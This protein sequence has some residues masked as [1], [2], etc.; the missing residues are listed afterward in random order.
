[1]P[2]KLRL[3]SAGGIYHVINR[4]NYRADL[5]RSEKTKAAFLNCLDEACAKTGWRVHAWCLMSNHDHLA[6]ETPRANLVE[7][8]RWLQGTFAT[9]F[10]RAAAGT[11]TSVPRA[12]QE[13]GCRPGGRAG[14]VV[15]LHPSQSGAGAGAAGR[16][17]AGVAVVERAVAGVAEAAAGMV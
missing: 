2:R 11:G 9:R 10:N 13:P 5:F 3:E 8:M 4:G 12:R 6:A 1:M 14:A 17:V 15:P 16:G 7:G